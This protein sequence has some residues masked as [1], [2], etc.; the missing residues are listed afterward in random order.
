VI[1]L[2]YKTLHSKLQPII[3]LYRHLTNKEEQ[4]SSH[5]T[6]GA[7]SKQ[8][9]VDAKTMPNIIG[10]QISHVKSM[11]LIIALTTANLDESPLVNT[12]TLWRRQQ[13]AKKIIQNH[14]N[15]EIHTQ[16]FFIATVVPNDANA[17]IAPKIAIII[18]NLQNEP[19]VFHPFFLFETFTKF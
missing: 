14:K 12:T 7:R 13:S 11:P 1:I 6:Q 9:P 19:D 15:N 3:K 10:A 8:L 2:E 5:T 16:S 18:N 4:A 17:L